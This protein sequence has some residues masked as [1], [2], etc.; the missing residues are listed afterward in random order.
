V[1]V[2][3]AEA[4]GAV[5]EA[6]ATDSASSAAVRVR[7]QRVA[8]ARNFSAASDAEGGTRSTASRPCPSRPTG[9]WWKVSLCCTVLYPIVCN[10]VGV[11]LSVEFDLAQL[12]KLV[13][14]PPSKTEDLAWCGHLDHYDEAYDKLSV[15]TA[16]PLKRIDNKIFYGHVTTSDVSDSM[17]ACIH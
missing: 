7:G 13:A 17:P 9:T 11:C 15:R 1:D 10:C 14:N 8:R 4:L 12:L 16:R 5:A 6:V 2:E 3:V